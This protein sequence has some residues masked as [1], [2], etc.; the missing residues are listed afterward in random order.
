MKTYGYGLLGVSRVT[1][2]EVYSFKITR[3]RQRKDPKSEGKARCAGHI[4]WAALEK[5][6][7]MDS[8]CVAVIRRQSY[9]L[10]MSQ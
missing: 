1:I 10:K 8:R 9:Y 6:E 4:P 2:L 7:Q 3:S 5:F